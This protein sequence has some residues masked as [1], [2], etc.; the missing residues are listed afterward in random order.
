MFAA[1]PSELRSAAA[2]TLG[3]EEAAF[4]R[5]F[6]LRTTAKLTSVSSRPLVAAET[7]SERGFLNGIYIM[8]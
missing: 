8:I 5:E 4:F 6:C 7:H 2:L 3:I 1:P